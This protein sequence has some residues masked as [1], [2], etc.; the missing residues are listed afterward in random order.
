VTDLPDRSVLKFIAGVL[1]IV[2]GLAITAVF[3]GGAIAILAQQITL[4]VQGRPHVG[5]LMEAL[6][7]APIVGG[8]PALLGLV[9][10]RMGWRRIRPPLAPTDHGGE[11]HE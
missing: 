8:A 11:P 1:M 3:G 6:L 10:A 7:V 4:A 9:L 2:A 5:G